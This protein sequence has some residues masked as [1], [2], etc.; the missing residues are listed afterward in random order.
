MKKISLVMIALFVL[1]A[2]KQKNGQQESVSKFF[3]LSK[4]Y[5]DTTFSD[6][7]IY[8][9]PKYIDFFGGNQIDSTT[10]SLSAEKVA[11]NMLW[12]E[13]FFGIFSFKINEQYVGLITRVPGVYYSPT[14]ISLWVYD[15]KADSICNSI[16]LSDIFGDAGA[17]ATTNSYLFFDNEKQLKAL[18][19][20]Y[21]LN[22]KS[23]ENETDTTVEETYHYYLTKINSTSID[24]ISVDSLKLHEQFKE[25][26][27]KM[28]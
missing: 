7:Y 26:L 20:V 10:L 11:R 1:V 12:T 9:N 3:Q 15:L 22:D 8:P 19:F 21:F 6:I 23:V 16:R 27:Q 18:T 25:Q 13:G 24:T 2:C 4:F 28:K 17:A 5:K 14:G